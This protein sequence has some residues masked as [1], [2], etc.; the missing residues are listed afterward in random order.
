MA[1]ETIVIEYQLT[2][3]DLADFSATVANSHQKKTPFLKRLLGQF[4]CMAFGILVV[5]LIII[6]ISLFGNGFDVLESI[7][8][9]VGM[10]TSAVFWLLIIPSLIIFLIL[11]Y[12]P[13]TKMLRKHYKNYLSMTFKNGNNKALLSP[14]TLILSPEFV[15]NENNYHHVKYRWEGIEKVEIIN[16]SLSVFI[17]SISAYYIPSRF[18]KSE[19]HKNEVFQKCQQWFSESNKEAQNVT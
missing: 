12:F 6:T 2:L 11:S 8:M 10:Y 9:V 16:N 18:F 14:S 13:R 3:D 4:K 19:E 1:D 7:S 17:S 5:S 15:R